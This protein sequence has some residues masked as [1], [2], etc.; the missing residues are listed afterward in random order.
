MRGA[1][2]QGVD[3]ITKVVQTRLPNGAVASYVW[4]TNPV[5]A[6]FLSP[7]R[8]VSGM[9]GKRTREVR[10]IILCGSPDPLAM[11]CA[12]NSAVIGD[13]Y[14]DSVT[15]DRNTDRSTDNQYRQHY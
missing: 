12:V 9:G 14:L 8:Q 5:A 13:V 7:C 2:A 1:G 3:L 10:L 4:H 6:R 15:T 11:S